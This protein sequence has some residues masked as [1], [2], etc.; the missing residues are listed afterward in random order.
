MNP[1]AQDPDVFELEHLEWHDECRLWIFETHG[2]TAPSSAV[3]NGT[4]AVAAPSPG[5]AGVPNLRLIHGGR[6]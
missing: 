5:A 2:F 1:A 6:K 3:M 4:P